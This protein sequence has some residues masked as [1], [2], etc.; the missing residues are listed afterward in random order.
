[1]ARRRDRL[2]ADGY[3]TARTPTLDRLAQSGAR[4]DRAYATAPITLTSHATIMTGRYP[5]GHRARHNGM[6]LDLAVPTLAEAFTR[7][8]A[9]TAAVVAALPCRRHAARPP[10]SACLVSAPAAV[11]PPLCPP[12]AESP[13]P[14]LSA[15]VHPRPP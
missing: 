8:G 14:S 6:R 4:F 7:A 5:P 11:G 9:S 13:L 2:G 1:D 15:P 10:D 3:R 12:A